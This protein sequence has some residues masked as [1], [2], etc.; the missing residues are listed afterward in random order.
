M[1]FV[2]ALQTRRAFPILPIMMFLASYFSSSFS[3]TCKHRKKHKS[4][5]GIFSRNFMIPTLKKN[6][7][8]YVPN[9]LDPS[10]IMIFKGLHARIGLTPL[11]YGSGTTFMKIGYFSRKT[12]VLMCGLIMLDGL[13]GMIPS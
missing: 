8:Y 12:E 7:W 5:L 6:I 10:F 13:S 3:S 1:N 11:K 4:K 2:K 9:T